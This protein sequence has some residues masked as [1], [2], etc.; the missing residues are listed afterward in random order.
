MITHHPYSTA[1]YSASSATVAWPWMPT[2]VVP[3]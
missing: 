1:Q 3:T 2:G